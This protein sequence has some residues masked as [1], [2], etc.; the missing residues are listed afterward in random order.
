MGHHDI[1]FKHT[2]SIKEHAV[3]FASHVLPAEINAKLDY[4]TICLE[5]AHLEKV[6]KR[7]DR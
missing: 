6:G 3:D 7:E 2:F 1:F 4:P 5:R